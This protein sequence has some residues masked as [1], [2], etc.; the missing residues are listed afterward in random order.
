MRSFLAL[1]AVCAVVSGK[2][3]QKYIGKLSTLQHDVSGDVYATDERSLIIENFKYDGAGPDAFF[4]V[5]KS[6]TPSSS[7]GDMTLILAHPYEGKNYEYRDDSAPVLRAYKG[8]TVKLT[9]PESFKVSDIKWLSIWCRKFSVD[10]GNT[11]F[12]DDLKFDDDIPAPLSPVDD[13]A[14]HVHA[15]PE[16]EPES[17][18]EP[19]AEP[20]AAGSIVSL[21][22]PALVFALIAKFL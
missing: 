1:A 15:E 18:P 2:I 7:A 19:E 6:G 4:W 22:L 21:A 9:L 10:F 14:N 3:T 5:G 13:D 20:K 16:P 12:P 11:I 17:E 8:E